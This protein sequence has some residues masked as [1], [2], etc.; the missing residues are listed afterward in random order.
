VPVIP[1][2]QE[3]EMG[4]LQFE[5]SPGL[6]LIE[7]PIPTNKPSTV[8]MPVIPTMWEAT[9]R[10]IMV[11]DLTW[12]KMGEL[13]WKLTKSK[14]QKRKSKGMSQVVECLPSN[15][16]PEFTAHPS[17]TKKWKEFEYANYFP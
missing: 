16:R 5:A 3:A 15:T 11:Q 7:A 1:A 9:G 6:P 14:K 10:K 12:T 2:A 8:H 13:T 17:T 4:P